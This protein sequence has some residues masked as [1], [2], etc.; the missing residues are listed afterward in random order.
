MVTAKI[1]ASPVPAV[2][3][4][5]H[6]VMDGIANV[7]KRGEMKFGQ[8]SYKYLKADD[9]QEALNPLL[10]EHGLIVKSDYSVETL[11]RG[12]GEGAPFVYVHLSLTY[13][14]VEDGSS[15][16]VTSVGEAQ[17]QDDKS[18][19]K[20]LTQAIKNTHRAT[21]Q[22]ASGEP[23]PDDAPPSASKPAAAS[24]TSQ[25]LD[26]ARPAAPV[27]DLNALKAAVRTYISESEDPEAT[28]KEVIALSDKIKADTGKSGVELQKHLNKELGL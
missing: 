17:A 4:A 13:I 27:A 14:A 28:R 23:E 3:G 11:S 25:K 24:P 8:T 2:Y 12:R 5:L 20:A 19:N 16:T 10:Q 26:K 9:V 21:F 15:L 6:K 7:P 1:E 22:F 18:I